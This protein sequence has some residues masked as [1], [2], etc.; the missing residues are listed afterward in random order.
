MALELLHVGM[1]KKKKRKKEIGLI[2]NNLPNE[3]VPSSDTFSA[4]FYEAC[5]EETMP[6]LH[7][8]FQEI[9][10]ERISPDSFY[11]ASISL[12][13]KPEKTFQGNH[14]PVSIMNIDAK[15]LNKILG[16]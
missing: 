15:I 7:N 11:E 9:E 4:E 13:I 5:E 2:I 3:E 16:N 8:L 12:I 14:R 1:A 6:I 10:S